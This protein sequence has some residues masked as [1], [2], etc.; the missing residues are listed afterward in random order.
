VDLGVEG[1]W[2]ERKTLAGVK[3]EDLRLDLSVKYYIN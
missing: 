3:G 1:L 2:A